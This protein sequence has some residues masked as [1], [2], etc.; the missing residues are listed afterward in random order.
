MPSPLFRSRDKMEQQVRV[1]RCAVPTNHPLNNL[2][3][4][5]PQMR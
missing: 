5:K 4:L 3:G 2:G 1:L